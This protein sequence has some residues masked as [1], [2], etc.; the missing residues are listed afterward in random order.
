MWKDQKMKLRKPL[1]ITPNEKHMVMSSFAFP[2]RKMTGIITVDLSK[3]DLKDANGVFTI[4][5]E[6]AEPKGGMQKFYEHLATQLKYPEQA[7]MMGVEGRVFV[8]FVVNTDGTLS[9]IQVLK[10]IGAGCDKEAARVIGLADPWEPAK[11]K[12]KNVKQRMVLPIVFAL[13]S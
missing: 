10:G 3:Y 5:E 13:G 9:D 8:E 2:D 11:Q 1:T 7:R 6:T 12:G 4:V